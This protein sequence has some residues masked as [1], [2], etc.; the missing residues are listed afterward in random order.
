MPDKSN[1]EASVFFSA[2]PVW[3]AG[4][5]TEMNL[6]VG[7]RS[8]FNAQA[9]KRTVLRITG[10]SLYRVFL[11]G[12]FLAHGPARAAHGYFRV[13][14]L[15]LTE[16][17]RPGANLL[18]IE[19]AGYNLDS[20]YL[21]DQPSF[22]Q[23]E[24]VCR[25]KVLTSTGGQCSQF[26]AVILKERVQKVP[27][28]SPQRTFAEVYCL[29]PG[30][31]RWR[32]D[33]Q[34]SFQTEKCQIVA[35]KTLLPRRVPY[36]DYAL[37]RPKQHVGRGTVRQIS[38]AGQKLDDCWAYIGPIR[39]G[40]PKEQ[41]EEIPAIELQKIANVEAEALGR[42]FDCRQ[43]IAL[44]ENGWQILDFGQ[45]LTGFIGAKVTCVRSMRLFITFDEILSDDDVDFKRF[46]CVNV[47][48]YQ[49]EP[50]TYLI[51]SF[52]PYTLRYAKLIAL[53]G[54]CR[55]EDFYLR[56]YANP[57]VWQAEFSATDSALNTLFQAGRETYRQNA[58][59]IFMDCPSRERSG[60]LCDSFFT[61][62]VGFDLSGN[63]LIEKNFL[64]NYLLRERQAH[65]PE[66]MLPMAYPADQYHGRFIPNWALWFVLQ[67]AEYAQRS[68]DW[69]M[70][71]ALESRVMRLFEY[72]RAFE[73]EEGLLEK[74]DGWV[75]IE[76][77]KANEFVQDVSYPSN[78][79]Y[80]AALA[81][82]GGLYHRQHLLGQAETI[83]RKVREQSFDGEFFVDNAVRVNGHLEPTR[84]RTEVCQYF[85][86]Y[87]GVANPQ[88]QPELWDNLLR[89]FSPQRKTTGA[90]PDVHPANAFIG[91]YLRLELLSRYGHTRQLMREL[92]EYFN[93]MVELTGTLWEHSDT[94]ASCCHGFASHVVHVLYRDILGIY[95]VDLHRKIISLR[96]ADLPIDHCSGYVPLGNDTISLRW[97]KKA[98]E[99]SYS[100]SL[101]LGYSLEIEN[102]SKHRAIR[103]S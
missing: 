98:D 58:V 43:G 14:E 92:Q 65:L 61:A 64:E 25:D 15:D 81:A 22:V 72:F 42:S 7:F 100:V 103:E 66:G 84:N 41:L 69:E 32:T 83:R 39:K 55:I 2:Q 59:D 29:D 44:E 99:L 73:N 10:C 11:N 79:L 60:W 8:L 74:L 38:L 75:F 33:I 102:L 97:L 37:K 82:A 34:A 68:R 80:A 13:D 40:Y 45:N 46:H 67:L 94:R 71:K 3:I 19:A 20:Y 54:S 35:T 86:F 51:E 27:R 4:R 56:E 70:V 26:E 91:N 57:D 96:F 23:A 53:K 6:F 90:F 28:Y 9:S 1:I 17:L 62:R 52:E 50:G 16:R 47:I 24:V 85:A 48:S 12:V 87:F 78:M 30:Y 77:S 101:P 89:H 18:A 76:W 5:E 36:P 88:T 93:H 31:S 49:M 21:L 95:K 63:T